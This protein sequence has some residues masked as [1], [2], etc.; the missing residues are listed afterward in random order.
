MELPQDILK[1]VAARFQCLG[2]VVRL[3]ILS[4]LLQGE[5]NV[6]TLARELEIGQASVSKHLAVLRENG[7]VAMHR[8]GVQMICRIDDD[9][10][11]ELCAL[12]CRKV[13]ST[14]QRDHDR[15]KQIEAESPH[16]L[17][18]KGD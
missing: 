16:V 7:F 14:L 10:V 5:A 8:Q 12:V 18:K 15:F 9:A 2:E 17:P 6:T 1:D 3:R 13:V 4:R 11:P